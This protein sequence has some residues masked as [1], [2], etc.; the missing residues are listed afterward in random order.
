MACLPL[1]AACDALTA[2][3]LPAGA[4]RMEPLPMYA[5]WWR[6]TEECSALGGDF[7]EVLWY[8][9]PGARS[10]SSG[11]E[12]DKQ[13]IWF[14]DG[15]I[16]LAGESVRSGPLVRHEMLHAIRKHGGHPRADFA[17]RC[18]GIVACDDACLTEGT[19]PRADPNALMVD[20]SALDISV[21]VTPQSPSA[22]HM[23]GYF[24]MIVSVRN[25]GAR[26][27]IVR[28]PPSGDAG[29]PVSFSFEYMRDRYGVSYDERAWT[30]E[31]TRFGPGETWRHVFDF[32][33]SGIRWNSSMELGT[34]EFR[35]AYGDKWTP[36]VLVTI[37]P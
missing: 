15:R 23:E 4:E 5:E 25:P 21:A 29:P 33:A 7:S 17:G 26:A 10:I 19:P 3:R 9:V 27:V 1:L 24:R 35:G 28:L 11:D 14:P 31:V 37:R 13:G 12:R 8:S 6:M 20:P 30:E 16:V 18:G 36:P 22:S 2:P 34:Y 32:W